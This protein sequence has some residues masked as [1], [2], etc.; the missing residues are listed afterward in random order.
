MRLKNRKFSKSN[1]IPIDYI[2]GQVKLINWDADFKNNLYG[3]E[4]FEHY[5]QNG[6]QIILEKELVPIF[7]REDSK[8][9][10]QNSADDYIEY[11]KLNEADIGN[12]LTR[13]LSLDF[14]NENK[15]FSVFPQE[16]ALFAED[17]RQIM[18][19]SIYEHGYSEWRACVITNELHG[20]LGIYAVIGAKM[21]I[22]VREYFRVGVD[23]IHIT[24]F[25]GTTPPFSCLNDGLQVSTGGT[26]GHGLINVA[27]TAQ[28]KPAATF[29]FKNQEVYMELKPEYWEQIKK[30][31]GYGVK[32]YGLGTEKYW[33]FVRKLA[34]KYWHDWDRH[35]IFIM[36]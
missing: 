4:L 21:G 16:E 24:S 17:V 22:R 26:L 12:L 19:E 36:N 27:G 6:K 30:D 23:D 20:H 7:L 28:T 31:I 13:S 3:E 33:A 11:Y 10:A 32:T 18:D 14:S 15:V 8:F 25:A 5:E 9:I 35:H 1:N 29:S 2:S 34:L